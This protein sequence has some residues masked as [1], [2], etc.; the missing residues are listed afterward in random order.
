MSLSYPQQKH[1]RSGA[2][3]AAEAS[4]FSTGAAATEASARGTKAPAVASRNG[5]A[6]ATTN[7]AQAASRDAWRRLE[8]ESPFADNLSWTPTAPLRA[9]KAAS[10]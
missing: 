2:R 1:R 8:D 5:L 10:R 3:A 9:A 4:A 6:N 7:L